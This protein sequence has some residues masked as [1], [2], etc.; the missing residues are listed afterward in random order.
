MSSLL[1]FTPLPLFFPLSLY[2]T[3]E[4]LTFLL[5]WF[6]LLYL[7]MIICCLSPAL[8][9][10]NSLPDYFRLHYPFHHCLETQIEAQFTPSV[11]IFLA[12]MFIFFDCERWCKYSFF[13][14]ISLTHNFTLSFLSYLALA[15]I[16]FDCEQ[17]RVHYFFFHFIN[18][19]FTPSLYIL[20]I[21][22]IFFDCEQW[23]LG[24]IN[25]FSQ[26]Q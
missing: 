7:A 13:F 3:P 24:Y 8:H 6:L 11:Y 15:F 1:I 12:S 5:H 10:N 23:H 16:F 26:F 21:T 18:I 22:L 19:Q 9:I 20:G 25:F 14:P 2:D 17:W 4:I